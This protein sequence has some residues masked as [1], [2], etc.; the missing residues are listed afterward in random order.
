LASPLAIVAEIMKEKNYALITGS[1]SG[2]GYEYAHI[3]AA[4]GY[5]LVL[6]SNEEEKLET[7]RKE[8]QEKF[9]ITSVAF[10]MDL[11]DPEAARDLY[12]RCSEKG[13]QV[14]VLINN[15]GI[16]FFGE[17][18]KTDPDKA[19]KMIQLH[20][21]TP[22]ILCLLFGKD[23][24][25]RRYGYI[26]NTA[27][28]ST[29]MPYPG[30]ALYSATKQYIKSLSRALRSE[31]LD[32]NVSVT[33]LC[34]GAVATNLFDRN[35]ID[36]KKAMRYGI[37]MSADKVAKIALAAMFRRKAVV[38]PGFINKVFSFLVRITP[39]WIIILIRRNTRLL[40]VD[41]L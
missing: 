11:A 31:M 22:S 8:L 29:D 26:L 36:Y 16:F 33:C 23:M 41:A 35:V 17:V 38:I 28:I 39:Q 21:L 25:K 20:V 9:N 4:Q 7:V 40:P 1:S 12:K 6:V 18:V 10:F 37:M 15:A 2:I 3:L 27:S 32:Y 34:P 30:I 13:I 24:K 5:N 14:D 19:S